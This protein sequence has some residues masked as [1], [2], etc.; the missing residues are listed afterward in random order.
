VSDIS[1]AVAEEGGFLGHAA[2]YIDDDVLH[3]LRAKLIPVG[4]T[5]FAK[6]GEALRLNRRAITTRPC[7]IDNNAAGLK[8]RNKL[9]ADSFIFHLMQKI[10][11]GSYSGGVV[12]S[13]NK[14]ALENIPVSAPSIN[15]QVKIADCLSSIDELVAAHTQKLATL[16]TH[17][18]GLMQQL[19]PAID[20]AQG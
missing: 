14:T 18:K 19:F 9:A 3:E 13:I 10:E 6:I 20:E 17:K 11:L 7:L 5:V 2:N 4:T 15:E 8:A 12:P 1:R 16:K